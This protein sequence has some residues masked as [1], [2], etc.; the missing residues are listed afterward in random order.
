MSKGNFVVHPTFF[1]KIVLSLNCLE[2]NP[3]LWKVKYMKVF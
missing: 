3:Q 1:T 2:N